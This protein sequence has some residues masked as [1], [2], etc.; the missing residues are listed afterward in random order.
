MMF[1]KDG[2]IVRKRASGSVFCLTQ[3]PT[4]RLA[5]SPPVPAVNWAPGGG[6]ELGADWS[7]SVARIAVAGVA[8]SPIEPMPSAT[9]HTTTRASLDQPE[10][11]AGE[12]LIRVPIRVCATKALSQTMPSAASKASGVIRGIR[13]WKPLTGQAS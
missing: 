6:T 1:A 9:E 2:P 13:Y 11:E 4:G 12:S 10:A 8:T 7:L 3:L 5:S